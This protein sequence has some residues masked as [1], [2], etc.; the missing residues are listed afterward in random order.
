MDVEAILKY[1]RSLS[2]HNVIM[3]KNDISEL[4]CQYVFLNKNNDKIATIIILPMFNKCML[5]VTSSLKSSPCTYLVYEAK[6]L[7]TMKKK[8]D[9]QGFHPYL[10]LASINLN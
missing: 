9:E 8:L 10:K 4:I 2:T 3:M 6:T 1:L 5:M 7:A